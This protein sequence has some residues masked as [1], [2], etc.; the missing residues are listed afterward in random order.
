M[1]HEDLQYSINEYTYS[2]KPASKAGFN[3]IELHAAIGCLIELFINPI[4]INRT[5]QHWGSIKNYTR[6]AAEV[7]ESVVA[8]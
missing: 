1:D 5:Y 4:A 2:A 3:D 6:L 8:K 7:T